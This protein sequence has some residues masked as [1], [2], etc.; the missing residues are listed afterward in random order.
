MTM[1]RYLSFLIIMLLSL[2]SIV[3]ADQKDPRLNELFFNLKIVSTLSE[4]EYLSDNIWNI[5]SSHLDEKI[6][7]ALSNGKI[8]ASNQEHKL[9]L[10][11]FNQVIELDPDFAEG[12]NKRA[13]LY[14]MAGDYQASLNDIEE[15]LKL[16]PRHFGALSGRGMCYIK[17]DNW[18]LAISAFKK[19]LDVNPWLVEAQH[20]IDL[21]KRLLKQVAF[22][23]ISTKVINI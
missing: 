5:W 20:N 6:N 10:Q 17:L 16:E 22:N 21:L 12:W 2:P 7:R 4:A 3:L 13:T 11:Y 14:Y 8:A 18:L 15:T 23:G 9:A 1:F 19:A